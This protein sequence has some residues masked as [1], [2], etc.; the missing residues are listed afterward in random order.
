M[1]ETETQERGPAFLC[2]PLRLCALCVK[3]E[4][5]TARD[6]AVDEGDAIDAGNT[7]RLVVTWQRSLTWSPLPSHASQGTV[8]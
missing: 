7:A 1:A 3:I 8:A 5:S 4:L 2:G 6:T